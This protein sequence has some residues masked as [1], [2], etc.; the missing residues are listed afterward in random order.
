MS[1]PKDSKKQSEPP[2]E[3]AFEYTLEQRMRM[4]AELVVEKILDDRDINEKL[5][6]I[7]GIGG[8][9]ATTK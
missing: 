4:V 1:S 6:D 5:I 2:V 8:D 3:V 9:N 7:L